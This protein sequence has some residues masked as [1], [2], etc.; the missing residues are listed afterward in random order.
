LL[1]KILRDKAR[2]YFL[3]KDKKNEKAV[4]QD[5][6][7]MYGVYC[8]EMGMQ[9]DHHSQ[10]NWGF[11]I[12]NIKVIKMMFNRAYRISSTHPAKAIELFGEMA[13]RLGEMLPSEAG[14]YYL[15]KIKIE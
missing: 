2:L 9:F 11:P 15:A 7:F 4:E 8:E 3:C 6:Q 1:H 13:T 14:S 10:E 12:M 5:A